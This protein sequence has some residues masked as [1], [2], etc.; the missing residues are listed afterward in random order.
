MWRAVRQ[1]GNPREPFVI[2]E[3]RR[4]APFF[5][6]NLHLVNRPMATPEAVLGT[7]QEEF[8]GGI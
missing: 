6:F 1:D 5:M 7:W 4:D 2:A 3:Q 8:L